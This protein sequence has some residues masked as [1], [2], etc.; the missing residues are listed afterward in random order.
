MSDLQPSP[1]FEEQ[2]RKAMNVPDAN[3]EFVKKLHNELVRGPV[4][5]KSRS[6]FR[7]AWG[8]AFVLALAVLVVSVPGVAAAF[9]KLLGYQPDVGLVENTGDLRILNEPI[10][11]TREGVTLTISYVLVDKDH[12]EVIYAAQG[13]PAQNDSWQASDSATNPKAFCGGV[14][15]GDTYNKE[16]DPILK[17]SDGTLLER[18]LTGKYPQNVFAMKPVYEAKIPANVLEMTFLLKCIPN[19]RLGAV[20]ENWEVPIKLTRVPAGTVVGA[21][22]IEVEQTA[23]VST[24]EMPASPSVAA[25]STKSP[26]LPAPVVNMTLDKVVPIDSGLVFYIRFDVENKNPSLISIMPTDVYVLDANGEKIRPY[27]NFMWQPS[28][29][30]VGSEFEYTLQ[31]KP[32]GPVTLVVEKAVAVYDTL[33]SDPLQATPKEMNFT[34]NAGDNPQYNQTWSLDQEF[35]IA[36]Y[37]IKITSVRAANYDDI[38][39]PELESFGGSQGFEHGYDFLVETDPSVKFQVLMDIMSETYV[40]TNLIGHL[41]EPDSSS[42]HDVELCRGDTYPKGEMLVRFL[43]LSVLMDNTWQVTWTP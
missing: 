10:S 11:M 3:P 35:Q 9:G 41:T 42:L 18:D 21:P 7:P 17:L 27:G 1:E 2:I 8:L 14:E 28:E 37:P 19:A 43:Q 22:V 40:C 24:T 38:K 20:P 15:V 5:M 36:G 4:K 26:A 33:S 16:G 13:I 6:M 12:V 23:I 39:T 31:S 32:A 30:R 29:H 34:F 25:S